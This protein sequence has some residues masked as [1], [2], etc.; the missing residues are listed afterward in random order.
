MGSAEN[1]CHKRK[2]LGF[3]NLHFLPYERPRKKR[4]PVH[5]S[6]K[7]NKTKQIRSYQHILQFPKTCNF[8]GNLTISAVQLL[9]GNQW[10]TLH[11]SSFSV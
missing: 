9:T 2:G 10:M 11:T 8:K 4:D 5:D 6:A 3:D 1:F 7:N